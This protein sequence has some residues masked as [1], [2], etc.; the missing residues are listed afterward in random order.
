VVPGAAR[1]P[2]WKQLG[3]VRPQPNDAGAINWLHIELKTALRDARLGKDIP[4]RVSLEQ[5]L[6]AAWGEALAAWPRRRPAGAAGVHVRGHRHVRGHL[7]A[8]AGARP[9]RTGCAPA[10]RPLPDLPAASPRGPIQPVP[11][12]RPRGAGRPH[13]PCPF[14]PACPTHPPCL[15]SVLTAEPDFLPV[16]P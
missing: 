1:V 3:A 10:A 14:C 15:S 4:R 16:I 11:W 13:P 6:R 12:G 7:L 9:A 8:T 5:G 2:L